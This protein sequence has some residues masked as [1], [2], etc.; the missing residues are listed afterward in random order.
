ML[1]V[2]TPNFASFR[3]LLQRGDWPAVIPTGHLYYFADD[4]LRKLLTSIGFTRLINLTLPA[5]LDSEL[6]SVRANGGLQISRTDLEEI[7]QQ[8]AIEDATKLSNGRGEGL[9]M[10]ALKPRSE[11]DVIV[12][13][14]RSSKL[15][16]VLDDKLVRRSGESVEDQKVY[17]VREGRKHWVTTVDWLHKHGMRLEQTVQVDREVLD[18]ILTGPSLQ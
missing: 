17:L 11:R 9:V 3:S 7:R 5:H 16:P 14:L 12:A 4:T 13:S 1:Y 8:T 18:N 2:T 6:D 10:C 15:M